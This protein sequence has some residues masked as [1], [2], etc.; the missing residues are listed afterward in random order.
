MLLDVYDEA[1]ASEVSK[2]M[3]AYLAMLSDIT[4]RKTNIYQSIETNT[5]FDQ[6]YL[7]LGGMKEPRFLKF[8]KESG[9]NRVDFF[10]VFKDNLNG[11]K[12]KIQFGYGFAPI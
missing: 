10:A 11:N 1:V 6:I 4:S 5:D 9:H 3:D 2:A 7:G 8:E 12:F